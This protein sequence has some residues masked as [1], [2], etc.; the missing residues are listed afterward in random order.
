MQ[1]GRSPEAVRNEF[2]DESSECTPD[3]KRWPRPT[4]ILM[5][6][7]DACI[8]VYQI[9]HSGTRNERG[10]RSRKSIIFRIRNKKRQPDK[11]V[12]G[13]TDHP[14]GRASS[15]PGVLRNRGAG[16]ADSPGNKPTSSTSP[17]FWHRAALSTS[18]QRSS[19]RWGG[20]CRLVRI[21]R[22]TEART[23]RSDRSRNPVA[24]PSAPCTRAHHSLRLS[25]S[26]TDAR[27]RTDR[28]TL[29]ASTYRK[30]R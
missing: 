9:P 1:E 10:P 22:P 23:R 18:S 3:G 30:V 24:R 17:L 20:D 13:V 5:E 27:Q 29:R 7:G 12:N 19:A 25:P 28:V 11:H 8:A 2:L 26:R 6:P 16:N 4:Q 14:D 15:S 21:R